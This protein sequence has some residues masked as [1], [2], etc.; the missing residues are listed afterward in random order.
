MTDQEQRSRRVVA[1]LFF[2]ALGTLLASW[3]GFMAYYVLVKAKHGPT[4]D[5]AWDQP[6]RTPAGSAAGTGTNSTPATGR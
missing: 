4:P 2:L 6:T 3:I 5:S 1:R